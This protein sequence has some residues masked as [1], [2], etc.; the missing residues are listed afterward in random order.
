MKNLLS[1][2]K[3]N[4]GQVCRRGA[5]ALQ[6]TAGNGEQTGALI[7]ILIAVV[8]GAVLLI[9]FGDQ[10]KEM[11]DTIGGKIDEMFNYS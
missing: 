2:V 9:A 4:A 7:L 8:V 5:A 11:M 3:R 6:S 10:V 1:K